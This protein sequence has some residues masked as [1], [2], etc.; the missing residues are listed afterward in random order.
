MR[1]TSEGVS[2]D[3]HV[4]PVRPVF[5]GIGSMSVKLNILTRSS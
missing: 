2:A 1:R 5:I 3:H 4:V